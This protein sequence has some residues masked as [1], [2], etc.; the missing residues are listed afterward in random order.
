M[1]E[2]GCQG[3]LVIGHQCSCAAASGG[4]KKEKET[5]SDPEGVGRRPK[6][7]RELAEFLVAF[8]SPRAN[9]V[10]R[11]KYELAM[12]TTAKKERCASAGCAVLDFRGVHGRW[13]KL[14]WF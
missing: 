6:R 4:A 14:M 11:T 10:G 3:L 2:S 9:R 13:R 8:A 12:R 5:L 7:C 1:R